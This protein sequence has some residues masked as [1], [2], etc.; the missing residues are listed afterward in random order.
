MIYEGQGS[1]EGYNEKVFGASDK[2][3][4][5]GASSQEETDD[6]TLW[7]TESAELE[8]WLK[9]KGY[10]RQG[11]RW[12]NRGVE[13]DGEGWSQRNGRGL[14]RTDHGSKGNIGHSYD[15]SLTK[16]GA[17]VADTRYKTK[18]RQDAKIA[19]AEG[20][21]SYN[22]QEFPPVES[23][24]VPFKK[25]AVEKPVAPK[26]TTDAA[27]PVMDLTAWK[28]ARAKVGYTEEGGGRNSPEYLE[29]L[30]RGDSLER[31]RQEEWDKSHPKDVENWRLGRTVPDREAAYKPH[32]NKR[33]RVT[34]KF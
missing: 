2:G 10:A 14:Q 26:I 32:Q 8:Q 29:W 27:E 31:Q 18:L 24:A 25:V 19:S 4:E 21:D 20:A 30:R 3:S 23:D 15:D 12:D 17:A 22:Y 1:G 13:I 11:A 9:M 5:V 6:N 28:E 7:E 33:L 34:Q 16:R